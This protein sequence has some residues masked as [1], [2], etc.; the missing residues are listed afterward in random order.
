MET[1]LPPT[2]HKLSA[3]SART[4]LSRSALYREAKKGRLKTLKIGRAVRVREQDLIDFINALAV[5]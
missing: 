1:Q 2:L 3:V 4:G 5:A